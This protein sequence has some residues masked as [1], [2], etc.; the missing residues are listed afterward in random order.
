MAK[1]QSEQ[2]SVWLAAFGKH[3]GWDDHIDDL[4]LES[5]RLTNV[6]RVLYSEGIAG[7]I[8]TGSWDK[9]DEAARLPGFAHALVWLSGPDVFVGR[10]WSSRDGKGR[11]KYPMCLV[12]QA[13]NVDP[14]AFV[15]AALDRLARAEEGCASAATAAEV[16]AITDRARR[17]MRDAA[18]GMPK[19][20]PEYWRAEGA[21][22][23]DIADR[24]ELATDATRA[25]GMFRVLYEIEKE[26][27]DYRAGDSRTWGK[28]KASG[29]RAAHLRVPVWNAEA[30]ALF[31]GWLGVMRAELDRRVSVLAILPARGPGPD[32]RAPAG[33]MDLIVGEPTAAQLFCVRA[34]PRTLPLTT[35][36]PYNL[37]PDFLTAAGLKIEGWRS[38]KP[39]AAPASSV[40]KIAQAISEARE[41]PAALR[42]EAAQAIGSVKKGVPKG[43]LIGAGV[44]VPVIAVAIILALSSGGK[45]EAA[46]PQ[47]PEPPS[48]NAPEAPP[49]STQDVDPREGWTG[50]ARAAGLAAGVEG[51]NAG[52]DEQASRRVADL[53]ARAAAAARSVSDLAARPADAPRAGLSASVAAL[54]K[55]LTELE[56]ELAELD[57]GL[58]AAR[59]AKQAEIT[60]RAEREAAERKEAEEA[61]RKRREETRRLAEEADAKRKQ[62]A[63][64]AR[65]QVEARAQAERDRLA[66]EAKAELERRLGRAGVDASAMA[67]L[68]AS[69]YQLDEVP[70]A[71]GGEASE[72]LGVIAARY[73]EVTDDAVRNAVGPS[74]AAIDRLRAIGSAEAVSGLAVGEGAT[75]S[76]L[77]AAFRRHRHVVESPSAGDAEA[78]RALGAR[79]RASAAGLPAGERREAMLDEVGRGLRRAWVAAFEQSTGDDV[80]S[81]L[82]AREGF[83]VGDKDL[84]DLRA[85][86]RYNL[87]LA[88]LKQSSKDLETLV[89]F[90]AGL[91]GFGEL[92]SGPAVAALA[93]AIDQA[94]SAAEA[95]GDP[96][97]TPGVTPEQIAAMGPGS[98]GWA[99][100]V[101]PD[102]ARAVFTAPGAGGGRIEFVRVDVE[103]GPSAYV[104]A[105]EMTLG[106]FLAAVGTGNRWGEAAKLLPQWPPT[107]PDPRLGPRVWDWRADRSRA[108]AA[109]DWLR[110]RPGARPVVPEGVTIPKPGETFPV[111]QLPVAAGLYAARLLG[112]RIPS[113]AEFAAAVA[114]EG[115]TPG[116]STGANLRDRAWGKMQQAVLAARATEA[117]L[118]LADAG[119]FT[120][121]GPAPGSTSATA[122]TDND[123]G[124]VWFRPA[125]AGP[126]STFKNLIGN[127][128]ELVAE[129][130][131][132]LDDWNGSVDGLRAL[133]A[134]GSFAVRV[135]GGSALSPPGLALDVPAAVRP[136]DA[137]R[138]WADVGLRLAFTMPGAVA[139]DPAR[140]LSK[141]AAAVD[142]AGFL[143]PP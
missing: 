53:R 1:D 108:V 64:E 65:R 98:V 22:L 2:P 92:A 3:P 93:L 109:A 137:A 113:P 80:T 31:L 9:L 78:L 136:A 85:H 17:E 35:E 140:A 41:N 66:A 114:S 45:K 83:G 84:A 54:D 134:D 15:P 86:A 24:P 143:P 132:R 126:G 77:L 107:R 58:R 48:T 32:G 29:G 118:D 10:I 69:G 23:A 94:Q 67:G 71:G 30:A 37:E 52:G 16:K 101:A 73:A 135:V 75:L 8:E 103:G 129:P 76:E 55:Q 20:D 82:A 81:L 5:E 74:L 4:G 104:S 131:S 139:A 21:L 33:W 95:A 121:T 70:P 26:M 19:G 46:P 133:L 123:D 102:G 99:G 87:A 72:A 40:A 56:A 141:A 79:V 116:A 142:S 110:P 68:L 12:A 47:P 100:Q 97:K 44:G 112:C 59:E 7:N 119:A 57:R 91:D 138:G 50:P 111:Q 25:L 117:T 11:T 49:V 38:G 42:Q 128:A 90:R 51:L 125:D 130:A 34:H 14:S 122:A 28:S 120:P 43:L 62:E 124:S 105:T 60:Q 127:V 61:D 115:G 96:S 89:A 13:T 106:Q 36:I 63:E 39:D 27:G 6:K 88:G 18:E